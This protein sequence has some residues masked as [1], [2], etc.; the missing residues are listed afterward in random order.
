MV[1]R[2]KTSGTTFCNV[3]I[4]IN[5]RIKLNDNISEILGIDFTELLPI[6]QL[7]LILPRRNVGRR[8]WSR[9]GI[10]LPK[11]YYQFTS[12]YPTLGFCWSGRGRSRLS[13]R[14]GGALLSFDCSRSVVAAAVCKP[15]CL[16][17]HVHCSERCLDS[18]AS[19]P[20]CNYFYYSFCYF[21]YDFVL[22]SVFLFSCS[23]NNVCVWG[24]GPFAPPP[25]TGRVANQTPGGARIK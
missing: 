2:S 1:T 22:F 25:P 16:F 19:A 14:G 13:W 9:G 4:Y 12:I 15:I 24:E 20:L 5:E 10:P 21:I 8:G 7:H 3:P 6:Q 18:S 11:I 17:R 23:I